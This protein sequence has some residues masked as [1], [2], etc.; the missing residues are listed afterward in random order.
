MQNERLEK[1]AEAVHNAW[2]QEKIKQG[3]T[4][5]PDMLPYNELA[6]EVKAY[7][8]VTARAVLHNLPEYQTWIPVSERLPDKNATYHLVTTTR[9]HRVEMAWYLDGD[10]FWN[11]SV[12]EMGG[13]IAWMP[14][15]EPYRPED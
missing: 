6:E 1:I 14:L 12:S 7:V 11:N 5:H 15:P 2:W 4:N 9:S 13:V 8:R 3:V 10:W